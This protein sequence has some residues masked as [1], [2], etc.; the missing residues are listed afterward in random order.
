[1]R[2]HNIIK[3]PKTRK[4]GSYLC[5]VLATRGRL[6]G[7]KERLQLRDRVSNMETQ[8]MVCEYPISQVLESNYPK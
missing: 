6:G 5:I 2:G 8:F 1:M 3:H 7:F 4:G